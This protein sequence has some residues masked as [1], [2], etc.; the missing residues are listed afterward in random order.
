MGVFF[1]TY[2]VVLIKPKEGEIGNT[3]RLP[4]VLHLLASA[5]YNV[6]HL[7]GDDEF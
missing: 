7:V 3:D 6:G 2:L 5:V 4:V 1:L